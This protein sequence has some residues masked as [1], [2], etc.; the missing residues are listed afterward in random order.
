MIGTF[1]EILGAIQQSVGRILGELYVL[2]NMHN[3]KFFYLHNYEV[4][5]ILCKVR[6]TLVYSRCNSSGCCVLG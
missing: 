6:A 5:H 2:C 4:C 3:E 1:G